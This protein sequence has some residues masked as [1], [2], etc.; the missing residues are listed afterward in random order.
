MERSK[1]RLGV[2]LGLFA[3]VAFSAGVSFAQD[4]GAGGAPAQPPKGEPP[5]AGKPPAPPDLDGYPEG[6]V[7]EIAEL[8]R[9]LRGE[10]RP[11]GQG[12]GP[13][14]GM[15]P[16]R[17]EELLKRFD[18][19]GD[20]Q[21]DD[22]ER[23]EARKAQAGERG[24]K[25]GGGGAGG[26]GRGPEDGGDGGGAV[27]GAGAQGPDDGQGGKDAGAA[28]G[29]GGGGAGAGGSGDAG[30]DPGRRAEMVKKFDKD[31]DGKLNDEERA[32]AMKAMRAQRE[33]TGKGG[34]NRGRME[35][36]LR[37]ALELIKKHDVDGDKQLSAEEKAALVADVKAHPAGG[38]G[39]R[40]G[41]GKGPGDAKPPAGGGGDAGAG[42]DAGGG[43]EGGK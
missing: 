2:V 20:G 22:E 1:G 12:G 30:M 9:S 16:G 37:K 6:L 35:G 19:N 23:A 29:G 34:E 8:L 21:L 31:G 38:K 28:A 39:P 15:D 18:K 17:K 13:G 32:E 42:G 41:K 24:K 11:G 7:R 14:G 10:G 25:G 43:G 27:G 36:L 40:E 33:K 4:D 3:S 26:R 5:K